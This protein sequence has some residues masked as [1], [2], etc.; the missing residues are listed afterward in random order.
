MYTVAWLDVIEGGAPQTHRG[1]AFPGNRRGQHVVL[2]SGVSVLEPLPGP[3]RS[4]RVGGG[5]TR[6]M[7]TRSSEQ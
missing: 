4:K 5:T 3:M 6:E 7:A 2:G 1:N